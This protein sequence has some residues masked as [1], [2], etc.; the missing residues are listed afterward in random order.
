M[1][2]KTKKTNDLVSI[3]KISDD[4]LILSQK[5]FDKFSGEETETVFSQ[6]DLNKLLEE[7]AELE[8][9][10]KDKNDL[11]ADIQK[12]KSPKPKVVDTDK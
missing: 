12:L 10:L 1:D 4:V 7:K 2:Y 3:N 6:L 11:I 5:T 9:L 8:A